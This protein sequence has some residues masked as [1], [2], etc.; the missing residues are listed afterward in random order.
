MRKVI[1]IKVE[2]NVDEKSAECETESQAQPLSLC[3]LIAHTFFELNK[4]VSLIFSGKLLHLAE[5]QKDYF[6]NTVFNRRTAS[7]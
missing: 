5:L 6:P 2:Y 7:V 1:T 4:I 3:E